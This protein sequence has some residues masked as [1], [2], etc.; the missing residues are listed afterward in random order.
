MTRNYTFGDDER[1]S[2]RLRRLAELYEQETRELLESGHS[3]KPHLAV[4][5]GC[6][7]G[8]STR[9][10]HEIL[11]PKRTVGLDSSERYI[12]EARR[13]RGADLDFELHDIVRVPFPVRAPDLM[14]CRFLLTH[15]I[16]GIVATSTPQALSM[17]TKLTASRFP[18]RASCKVLR[19]LEQSLTPYDRSLQS[20]YEHAL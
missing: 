10:V 3:Q 14:F 4:D 9:L 8:W 18:C 13:N 19:K 16:I 20:G 17:P 12:A 5:L 7:P 2:D 1:A 15:R 11:R 6:G